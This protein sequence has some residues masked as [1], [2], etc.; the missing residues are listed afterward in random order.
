MKKIIFIFLL[1]FLSCRE[2][3]VDPII[4]ETFED[5]IT[6]EVGQ[7][8]FSIALDYHNT[9]EL[10]ILREVQIEAFYEGYKSVNNTETVVEFKHDDKFYWNIPNAHVFECQVFISGF[11]YTQYTQPL[12]SE[13]A[14]SFPELCTF[15]SV[16]F[17]W[18]D[19]KVS[20]SL[21]SLD[22]PK[23]IVI[24]GF[25][26]TYNVY[27]YPVMFYDISVSGYSG[28]CQMYS[29]NAYI[30]GVYT[31][32]YEISNSFGEFTWFDIT[33]ACIATATGYGEYDEKDGYGKINSYRALRY[34]WDNE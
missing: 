8:V 21:D 12:I 33:D 15:Y 24:T 6:K 13:Y 18:F 2:N 22:L 10:K 28:T 7:L 9:E 20:S 17:P 29:S 16:G 19:Y 14:L 11:P 3:V 27:A 34:L 25:G 4:E 32:I 5:A 31:A 26:I 23:N 1:L 30:A